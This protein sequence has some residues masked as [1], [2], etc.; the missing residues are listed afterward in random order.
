MSAG[1]RKT[2]ICAEDGLP[3]LENSLASSL[4]RSWASATPQVA[5]SAWSVISSSPNSFRSACLTERQYS[6]NFVRIDSGIILV[7]PDTT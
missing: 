4:T 2:K 1:V 5:I 3:G 6:L 7:T